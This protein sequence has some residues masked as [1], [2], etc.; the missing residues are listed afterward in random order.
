MIYPVIT[1]R[2]GVMSI[3]KLFICTFLN[4]F[5][6]YSHAMLKIWLI[7][8]ARISA[9]QMAPEC[10]QESEWRF[11]PLQELPH[12]TGWHHHPSCRLPRRDV[13]WLTSIHTLER[14]DSGDS[15]M[16][17]SSELSISSSMP[18]IFPARLACMFWIKGKRRSPGRVGERRGNP[19]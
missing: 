11:P 3:Q 15:S 7:W 8:C 1:E 14:R 6:K 9:G 13:L 5:G 4:R 18:V 17:S 16:C 2:V 19:H 10:H 12:Q